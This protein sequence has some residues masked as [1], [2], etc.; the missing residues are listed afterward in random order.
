M[1][2][3]LSCGG[4]EESPNLSHCT[5]CVERTGKTGLVKYIM[6]FVLQVLTVKSGRFHGDMGLY[7]WF[8]CALNHLAED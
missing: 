8:N 6:K 1:S 4:D 5:K 7:I 3:F 2:N